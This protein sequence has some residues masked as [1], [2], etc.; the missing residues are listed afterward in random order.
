MDYDPKYINALT[1]AGTKSTV[2]KKAVSQKEGTTRKTRRLIN[3]PVGKGKENGN[4][5]AHVQYNYRFFVCITVKLSYS[6]Y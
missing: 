1:A 2:Q 3:K 6:N 4:I 5:Y